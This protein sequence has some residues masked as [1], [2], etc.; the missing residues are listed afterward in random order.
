M[1]ERPFTHTYFEEYLKEK[2]LMAARCKQCGRLYLPPR[3][4][5]S[6][7]RRLDMEWVQLK[8]KG[9]LAA[10]TCIAVG[11]TFMCEQGFSRDNLYCT[12]IVELEEGPRISARILGVDAQHP[13]TIKVGTPMTMDLVEW[14]DKTYLAF[15]PA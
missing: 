2:K 1:A 14:Q 3:P 8:G 6:D 13:E 5:C 12:G 4:M 10:F 11:P 9:K 15:R 7:C